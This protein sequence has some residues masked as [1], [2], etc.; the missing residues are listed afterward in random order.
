M[1]KCIKHLEF[2]PSTKKNCKAPRE[3]ITGH[4][5]GA[6]KL[7][8]THPITKRKREKIKE[9]Y[10]FS[11]SFSNLFHCCKIESVFQRRNILGSHAPPTPPHSQLS[12][13][14]NVAKSHPYIEP[15]SG[16][17]SN[18]QS[19]NGRCPYALG[20]PSQGTN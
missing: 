19:Q 13:I 6:G 10:P 11:G 5:F 17:N 18:L 16:R 9:R 8:C 12:H 2:F 15:K 20:R 4:N 14:I 1:V 7:L 3:G